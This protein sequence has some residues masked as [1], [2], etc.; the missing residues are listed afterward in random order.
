MQVPS[1]PLVGSGDADHSYDSLWSCFPRFQ[2][3]CIQRTQVLRQSSVI[4]VNSQTQLG[5][6]VAVGSVLLWGQLVR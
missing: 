1:S 6:G 3:N 2:S 5:I 4:H